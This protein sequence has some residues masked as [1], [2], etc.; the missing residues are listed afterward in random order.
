MKVHVQVPTLIGTTT[1]FEGKEKLQLKL[2]FAQLLLVRSFDM[3]L[4]QQLLV[5]DV[6]GRVKCLHLALVGIYI[7]PGVLQAR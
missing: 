7:A 2:Q 1:I 4:I 3:L 5:Q 6:G